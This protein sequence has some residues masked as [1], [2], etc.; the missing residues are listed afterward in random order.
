MA[1]RI[2]LLAVGGLHRDLR[3]AADHYLALLRPLADVRVREVRETPLRGRAVQEVLRDEGRRL[4]AAW[5]Q[6]PTVA[7]LAVQGR[8]CDTAVFSAW[9]QESL[10][11]GPVAFVIGGSLG[12]SPAAL[13]RAHQRLS[14]SALTLPHQLARVVLLEQ[15]FRALKIARGEPYHH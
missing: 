13:E 10:E 4:E 6:A 3:P 11:R 8:A 14:L 2:E 7:A 1:G 9:L 15:V 5:P 12:L